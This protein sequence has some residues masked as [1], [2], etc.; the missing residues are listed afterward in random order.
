MKLLAGVDAGV[1]IAVAYCTDLTVDNLTPAA[2]IRVLSGEAGFCRPTRWGRS[3]K[4]WLTSPA[5]SAC[6]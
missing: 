4:P 2:R 3:W 6:E 1:A 5:R